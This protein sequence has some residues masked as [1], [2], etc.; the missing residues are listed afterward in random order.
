[1]PLSAAGSAQ[2]DQLRRYFAHRSVAAAYS[3]PLRR[4]VQTASAAPGGVAGNVR[5]LR[6]LREIY[7]GSVEGWP[8]DAVQTQFPDLW[9]RNLEQADEA[10]RWPGGETYSEFRR[11]VVRVMRAIALRHAGSSV[12]VFTHAG[13]ISQMLGWMHNNSAARWASFRPGNAS[14]TTIV[15]GG[16]TW[17]LERFNDQDHLIS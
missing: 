5:L 4:S 10:F 7:C 17:L 12:V 1:V 9:R 6:S 3:S 2:V 16:G 13:V 8:V 14:I 11:R 15:E